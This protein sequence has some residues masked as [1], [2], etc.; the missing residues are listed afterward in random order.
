M[1]NYNRTTADKEQLN[2]FYQKVFNIKLHLLSVTKQN[3]RGFHGTKVEIETFSKV[4]NSL[5]YLQTHKSTRNTHYRPTL[6]QCA[7]SIYHKTV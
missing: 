7:L 5:R 4:N 1:N 3:E 2:L 6:A